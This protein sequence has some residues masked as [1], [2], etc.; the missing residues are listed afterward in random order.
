MEQHI[1]IQV[2]PMNPDFRKLNNVRQDSRHRPAPQK[3]VSRQK[4]DRRA[5]GVLIRCPLMSLPDPFKPA[6]VSCQEE[7][8]RV[9]CRHTRHT[10]HKGAYRHLPGELFQQLRKGDTGCHTAFTLAGASPFDSIL[11]SPTSFRASAACFFL[12]F[13]P[14]PAYHDSAS[15][16]P[17]PRYPLHFNLNPR[18]RGCHS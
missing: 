3:P 14:L 10:G 9:P 13:I 7:Y 4:I 18:V 1:S 12:I 15:T 8:R 17:E 5:H 16:R 6:P 2:N 11:I